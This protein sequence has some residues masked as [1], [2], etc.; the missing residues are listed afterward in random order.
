MAAGVE[1]KVVQMGSSYSSPEGSVVVAPGDA[2]HTA[3]RRNI[4]YKDGLVPTAFAGVK[5]QYEC[6]QRGLSVNPK[7]PCMGT[8][9]PTGETTIEKDDKGREK[10]C[11]KL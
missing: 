11:F 1:H 7:G 6:F 10:V 9:R 5:T 4:K 8:R 3:T 2:T